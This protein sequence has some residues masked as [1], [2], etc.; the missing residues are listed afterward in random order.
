MA[1]PLVEAAPAKLNLALHVTGRRADGYH[2]LEM[3]VAFAE[4]GDELEARPAARDS[5]AIT[6]PF[7]PALGTTEGNLVLR[8]LSAFRARWPAALPPGIALTLRKNLPVA[9]GLGGGSADAAA[10]LRLFA[11][12]GQG[13][14]AFADLLALAAPL[15]ADVPMCLYS[16]PAEVRGLGEIVLPL[17]AFPACH[18]VLINPLVPVVTADV[19]RRLERR[20]NPGLPPLPDPLLRPAQLALWLDETRNDLEPP[21]LA[22][23]PAIGEIKARLAGIDG[24]IL[25]RMS[26]SGATVFGLFGSGAQAHQAAHDLR[27]RYPDH[28]VAAAPLLGV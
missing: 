12:M 16:R 6:G 5:L 9:A 8:A 4:I 1:E 26:G 20:D 7:A 22:L 13:G 23:V 2:A 3:L 28:W 19:F 10:A 21:A 24:C 27:T 17:K 11:A 25:A 15:G 18:A 14:V